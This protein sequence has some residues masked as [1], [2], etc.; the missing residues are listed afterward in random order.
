[1]SPD[2]MQSA[3]NPRR[4][5]YPSQGQAYYLET[6]IIQWALHV[7]KWIRKGDCSL[8]EKVY[9]SADIDSKGLGEALEY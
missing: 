6:R 1:M 3:E 9:F 7:L 2:I 5:L 4:T 8:V